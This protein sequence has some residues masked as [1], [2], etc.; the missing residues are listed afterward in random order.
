MLKGQFAWTGDSKK[1]DHHITA[2]CA[3]VIKT[4][5]EEAARNGIVLTKHCFGN[6]QANAFIVG[7]QEKR[8]QKTFIG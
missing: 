1:G 8:G 4:L 7:V 3:D 2:A 5:D 6:V